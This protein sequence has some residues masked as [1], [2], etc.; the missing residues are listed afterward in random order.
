[1]ARCS[2]YPEHR[3]SCYQCESRLTRC[4]SQARQQHQSA[5]AVRG[6]VCGAPHVQISCAG[7]LFPHF[8]GSQP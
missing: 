7:L 1:M 2:L 3:M 4:A 8:P 6:D 5:D